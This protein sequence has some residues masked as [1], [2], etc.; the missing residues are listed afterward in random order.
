MCDGRMIVT[1]EDLSRSAKAGA[2][3]KAYAAANGISGSWSR[4][5]RYSMSRRELH[6]LYLEQDGRCYLCGD[7]LPRDLRKTAVDHDHSCCPGPD[8]EPGSGYV[9]SCGRCVRGIACSACNQLIALARD[10]PDRLRRIADNLEVANR[11]V[12][13]LLLPLPGTAL[14][15]SALRGAALSL[16]LAVREQLPSPM[17]AAPTA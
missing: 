10:D 17:A 3:W 11:Y 5:S 6:A 14:P 15:P 4:A 7:P 1:F 12:D 9:T 8:P 13:R 2:D 16:V